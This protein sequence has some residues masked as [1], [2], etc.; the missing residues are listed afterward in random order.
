MPGLAREKRKC[1]GR[2][3]AGVGRAWAKVPTRTQSAR[4]AAL[5]LLQGEGGEGVVASKGNRISGSIAKSDTL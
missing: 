3:W 4:P 5:S 2:G 1:T